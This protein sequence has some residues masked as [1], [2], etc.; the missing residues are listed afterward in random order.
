M[1]FKYDNLL[2]KKYSFVNIIFKS[3]LT[4]KKEYRIFYL[5]TNLG[6]VNGYTNLR[7][8]FKNIYLIKITHLKYWI[9]C[10]TIHKVNS[11]WWQTK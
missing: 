8:I 4:V 11:T 2:L 10:Q 1:N 7:L 6:N 9:Q 3:S 5:Q